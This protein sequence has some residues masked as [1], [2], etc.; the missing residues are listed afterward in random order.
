MARILVQDTRQSE[1][2]LSNRIR[3]P[4]RYLELTWQHAPTIHA[5]VRYRRACRYRAFIPDPILNMPLSLDAAVAGAVSEAENSIQALNAE[6]HP[7]LAPLARLLL[8]TESIASSKVEGMQ[9][10]A[11]ELARA[12]ARAETGGKASQTAMEIL[13]NIDAMELAVEEAATVERFGI[14]EIIS[15]HQRLTEKAINPHIAGRIRTE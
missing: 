7:A 1:P 11:R 6:A 15:I 14:D 13:S 4:G 9:L 5:P 10:G 8:R 3:M 2:L 12:E